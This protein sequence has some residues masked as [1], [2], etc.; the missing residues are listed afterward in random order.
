MDRCRAQPRHPPEQRLHRSPGR[1]RT[2]PGSVDLKLL[3]PRDGWRAF[4]GEVGVI[5]LGVLLALGAQQL[6]T[7]LEMRT[8][9]ASFRKTINAEI[10]E[11]LWSY[12]A[13]KRQDACIGRRLDALANWLAAVGP[14]KAAGLVD[15]RPP[16]IFG[17]SDT[18]W[19]TRDAEVFSALPAAERQHYAGFYSNITT[20][21]GVRDRELAAW[22]PLERYEYAA[23]LTVEDRRQIQQSIKAARRF[24]EFFSL[25]IDEAVA[26]A[27]ALGITSFRQPAWV[28]P[29]DIRRIEECPEIVAG[30][31]G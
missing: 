13:R 21:R 31:K 14:G 6:A 23:P 4:A 24:S 28:L 18:A 16:M 5:V 7:A 26:D 15:A 11:N 22:S 25:N 10:K 3:A 30:Q 1:G 2:A 12:A 19:T 17:L 27:N 9:V 8:R 29:V 20:N